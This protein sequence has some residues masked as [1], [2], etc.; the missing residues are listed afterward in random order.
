MKRTEEDKLT[1]SSVKVILGGAEYKVAPLVIRDSRVWRQKVVGV[2]GK[3]PLYLSGSPKPKIKRLWFR[4][5]ESDDFEAAL[6]MLLITMPDTVV[7]LFFEYAR[8][9]NRK[10]I[11][12][13]ATDHELAEA[14]SK[15]VEIAFPLARSL[16]AVVGRLSQSEEP[17]SS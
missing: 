9:L 3:L 11:E 8:D 13:K 16:P 17:S 1:Q 12:G 2:L 10:E 15:V 7:D 4:H 6:K 5:K 14:F